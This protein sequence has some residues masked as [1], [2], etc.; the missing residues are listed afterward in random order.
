MELFVQEHKKLWRKNI[1]KVSVFLCFAYVVIVGNILSFQWFTFGSNDD[2]TSSF[3]NRFDGYSVIRA[4]QEYADSYNFELTDESFQQMVRDY[5]NLDITGREEEMER[6][7]WQIINS[8]LETLYPEL[9]DNS[10]YKTMI[11]YVNPN[12]LTGL[13]ERRQKAIK[14]F[15]EISGQENAEKDFLLK[16][17]EKVERPFRYEWTE[18][19][20]QI[21]G[22]MVADLGVVMALFMAIALSSLFAGEWR[23]NTG[24]LILTTKNGWGKIGLAKVLTGFIFTA[25][26][27]GMLAAGGIMAQLF[28]M[29]T[30]GWNM[31]IQNMKMI[32]VAPM[33]MLQAE[34]YEYAFAFLGAIGFAGIVMLLSSAVK[35]NVLALLLS[36]AVVYGP[37][38]IVDYLPYSLQ[39]AMDLLPLVGSSTDIFRTNVF[40][41]FGKIIWSP[42]LLITVP[43]LLGM[44]CIPG[45]V[46]NWAKRLK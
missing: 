32:A 35:S 20:S 38:M 25:E 19:W 39:K 27:F 43:V 7:D 42:Y 4:S 46:R 45:T 14:D 33:N 12:E 22:S 24:S 16:M 28:F 3:G 13:Y 18:G 1:V 6:A 8:W 26:F 23:Y 36:L 21:L 34:I 30:S 11:S 40:Y 5:Q 31:P 41:V 29:G 2:F 44:L 17:N 9:K 15:L 37:I 10:I